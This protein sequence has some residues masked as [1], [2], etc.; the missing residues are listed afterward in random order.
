MLKKVSL[1]ICVLLAAGCTSLVSDYDI[2]TYRNLTELKGEIK[3][4]FAGFAENGASGEGDGLLIH[5]FTIR[6]AQA[7]EYEKGKALNDNTSAQFEILEKT[8]QEIESRFKEDGNKLSKGYCKAKW[9]VLNR[10]F[11][12]AIET[13]RNKIQKQ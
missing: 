7:L 2:H 8:I 3:V 12:L 11:D 4:A 10:A 1:Y 6:I 9:M 13:E 5:G